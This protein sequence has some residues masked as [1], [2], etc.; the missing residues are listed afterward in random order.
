M[1]DRIT[2]SVLVELTSSSDT[3]E[4]H[5]SASIDDRTDGLNAGRTQ[6]YANPS[7]G[8]EPGFLVWS[9]VESIEVEAVNG[10]AA[11][12]GLINTEHTSE[13]A[14]YAQ[15]GQSE[16]EISLDVPARGMPTCTID[17]GPWTAVQGTEYTDGTLRTVLL[18]RTDTTT[19]AWAVGG[20]AW[21]GSATGYRITPTTDA[22]YVM[23]LVSG[24]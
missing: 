16:I 19:G 9:T 24:Q 12:V 6:F 22:T 15:P 8:M 4:Q 5:L 7:P 3:T 20:L 11:S 21:T 18:R 10:T 23:L 17:Y 2:A 1:S 14:E 13:F